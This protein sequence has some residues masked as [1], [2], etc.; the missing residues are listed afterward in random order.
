M[1]YF[2]GHEKNERPIQP[3]LNFKS[4]HKDE[5]S[6]IKVLTILVIDTASAS[7]TFDVIY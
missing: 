6:D 7:F 2:I 3:C 5:W 4:E 1:T